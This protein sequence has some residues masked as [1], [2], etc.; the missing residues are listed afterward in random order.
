LPIKENI[1]KD[2]FNFNQLVDLPLRQQK[3]EFA[4][5]PSL[6]GGWRSRFL[7]ESLYWEPIAGAQR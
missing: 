3:S 5:L 2:G 7:R 1:G 4:T 6:Q